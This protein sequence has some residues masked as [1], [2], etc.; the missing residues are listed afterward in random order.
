[1]CII[2][3]FDSRIIAGGS[4]NTQEGRENNDPLPNPWA[5]QSTTANTTSSTTT[6]S[7]AAAGSGTAPGMMG[8]M[9]NPAVQNMMSQMMQNPEMMSSMMSSPMMQNTLS[10]PEAMNQMMASN[11]LFAANPQMAEAMRESMPRMMQQV[12]FN[13]SLSSQIQSKLGLK[14]ALWVSLSEF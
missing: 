11:P 8:M 13:F 14:T 6:P 1:M 4:E 7:T 9:N 12:H 5:P 3:T 2:S 10:N